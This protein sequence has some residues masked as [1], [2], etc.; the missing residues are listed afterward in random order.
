MWGVQ[1]FGKS[2]LFSRE[3][4]ALPCRGKRRAAFGGWMFEMW[5]FFSE[6]GGLKCGVFFVE[7][8]VFWWREKLRRRGQAPGGVWR[9][10]V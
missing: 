7:E 8:D 10:D 9:M 2:G 4:K 5:D 1:V 3:R 6:M